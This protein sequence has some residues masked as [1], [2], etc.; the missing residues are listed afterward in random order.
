MN[1]EIA[2]RPTPIE[3]LSQSLFPYCF[4]ISSRKYGCVV[5]GHNHY[6]SSEF[7][8]RWTGTSKIV[9]YPLNSRS[10][11]VMSQYS[12]LRWRSLRRAGFSHSH[13]ELR[14][15]NSGTKVCYSLRLQRHDC[16]RGPVELL[17]S[18]HDLDDEYEPLCHRPLRFDRQNVSEHDSGRANR[19]ATMR[20]GRCD[21]EVPVTPH[22]IDGYTGYLCTQCTEVWTRLQPS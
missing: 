22:A 1:L 10:S 15:L 13:R 7:K 14:P 3:F 21:R 8:S 18:A 20:C 2:G 4:S 16:W 17:E 12:P 6:H 11:V 5:T 9:S 19:R